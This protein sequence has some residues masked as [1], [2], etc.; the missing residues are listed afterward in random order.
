MPELIIFK[1][2]SRTQ[3]LFPLLD[4][5][6]QVNSEV[7]KLSGNERCELRMKTIGFQTRTQ[8]CTKCPPRILSLWS[9]DY[10]NPFQIEEST[11]ARSGL[12]KQNDRILNVNG[13]S[14]ESVSQQTAADIIK[15]SLKVASTH[16]FPSWHVPQI[17]NIH[18]YTSLF[19]TAHP[20][21]T[22]ICTPCT[23]LYSFW[24]T[25]SCVSTLLNI[26]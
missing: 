21:S 18:L 6:V 2:Y 15:V 20:Y 13:V 5:S 25:P 1:Y 11:A 16:S 3:K 4:N 22:L 24:A 10:L 19:Y 23:P 17:P 26:Q 8:L 7:V 12:I 9:V 14:L